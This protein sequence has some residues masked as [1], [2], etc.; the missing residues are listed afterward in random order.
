M[1]KIMA[2]ITVPIAVTIGIQRPKEPVLSAA[3]TNATKIKRAIKPVHLSTYIKRS[4]FIQLLQKEL[5]SNETSFSY[6]VVV[7]FLATT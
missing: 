4:F 7:V 1:S 6:T 5:L 2:P 3:T